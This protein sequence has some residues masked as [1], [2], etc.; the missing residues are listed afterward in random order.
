MPD[1]LDVDPA[2]VAHLP[3]DF[4]HGLLGE[5]DYCDQTESPPMKAN[6]TNALLFSFHHNAPNHSHPHLYKGLLVYSPP[7]GALSLGWF[8]GTGALVAHLGTHSAVLQEVDSSQ[9][10]S[11]WVRIA[12][13]MRRSGSIDPETEF[14]RVFIFAGFT[15]LDVSGQVLGAPAGA[16]RY[17]EADLRIERV[18]TEPGALLTP[19]HLALTNTSEGDGGKIH[20]TR[21][22]VVP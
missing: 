13:A 6:Q 10:P 5:I 16:Q 2:L 14:D 12:I 3:P 4:V 15:F 8:S 22:T 17:F 19:P 7:I 1:M 20:F 9:R 18:P 21:T 11:P